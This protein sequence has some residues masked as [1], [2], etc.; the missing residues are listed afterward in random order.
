MKTF[1]KTK[2]I[3][4]FILLTF[5]ITYFFW[6][7]PVIIILPKDIRFAI[8]IFGGSGPL[9]AGYIIMV[10]NSGAKFK[11]GSKPIFIIIFIATSIVFLLRLYFINKGLDDR[12]FIPEL[13]EISPGGYISF[14]LIFFIFGMNASNATNKALKENHITTF[15]FDKHKIKWYFIG[16]LLWPVISLSSYFIGHLL[17]LKTTDFVL[18]LEPVWFIG[19]FATLFFFGGVEEFGWR[20]FLQKEMQKRYNPLITALVIC[21]IWSLWHLPHYYNGVYS[22]GGFMDFLPRFIFT[23]PL[24]I[25]FTWFYNKSSYD[26]LSVVLLHSMWSN[27]SKAFGNGVIIFSGLIFLF[28]IYCII[29]DKMWKKKT[30][31]SI[32]QNKN[33]K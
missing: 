25:V 13:N 20:G 29:D 18:K 21:F 17:G 11:I 2:P 33:Y 23:L 32:Y 24:A 6:F 31:H 8:L 7:L 5:A 10:V 9:L 28:C 19:F 26:L 16:L 1:F 22:I 3:L 12:G 30:Y 4:S 14:A 27:Y 15:L